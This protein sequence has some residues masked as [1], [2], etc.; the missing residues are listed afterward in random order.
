MQY[1][2]LSLMLFITP[3]TYR[4]QW[5]VISCIKSHSTLILTTGIDTVNIFILEVIKLTQ[6]GKVTYPSSHS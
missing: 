6:R 5:Y 4:A 3:A 1:D 2:I